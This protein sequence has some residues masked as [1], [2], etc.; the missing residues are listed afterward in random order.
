MIEIL[1]FLFGLSW[2][3]EF[4][5]TLINHLKPLL[6][7]K[8]AKFT[9]GSWAV[10]SACTDGIGRSFA[11]SLASRG[12]NIIQVA[13]NPSKLLECGNDL[14][15]KFGIEVKNIVKDFSLCSKDP[16]SF[17]NEI[18]Q[19]T[20]E[21]DVRIVINNVGTLNLAPVAEQ[22]MENLLNQLALNLFPIVFLSRV[23]LN[24]VKNKENYFFVN[25]SSVAANYLLKKR[26]LYTACKA[27]DLV[28]SEVLACE[29][30]KALALQPAYT[31][32]PLT[33]NSK[34]RPLLVSP[35]EVVEAALK[36]VDVATT[37]SGHWKHVVSILLIKAAGP[38]IALAYMTGTF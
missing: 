18:Y 26:V 22:K 12:I 33:R 38:F 13:R 25:L 6:F 16:I 29:G 30:V 21:L 35:M 8:Q 36:D 3:A 28:F 9:S 27:F 32:T 15:A 19:E 4:L 10:I 11:L 7:Q 31:D 17:F 20:K 5:L 23:Y 34:S 24:Q 2:S 37:T 14:K 1:L